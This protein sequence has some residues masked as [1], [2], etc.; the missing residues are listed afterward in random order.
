MIP[1]ETLEDFRKRYRNCFVLLDIRGKKQ[2]VQYL[3]DSED[4]DGHC[5]FTFYSPQFGEFLV[6]EETAT[7]T[8]TFFFP[9]QGHYNWCGN[10]YYFSRYPQRQWKRAPCTDNTRIITSVGGLMHRSSIQL[11]TATCEKFFFPEYPKNL[12]EALAKLKESYAVNKDFSLFFNKEIDNNPILLYHNT[13]VALINKETKT[14]L[15]KFHP[16]FQEVLDFIREKEPLWIAIK[17]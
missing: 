4:E 2:L 5:D 16:L 15:V 9:E 1:H 8:L 11:T 6:D 3:D 17:S 12:E 13:P 14:I 7:E 10:S